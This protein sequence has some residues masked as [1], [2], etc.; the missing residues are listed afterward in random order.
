MSKQRYSTRQVEALLW[1]ARQKERVGTGISIDI[2]IFLAMCNALMSSRWAMLSC[3][4]TDTST[5]RLINV[6]AAH[7]VPPSEPE[8]VKQL[9]ASAVTALSKREAKVGPRERGDAFWPD[10]DQAGAA[11]TSGIW[12]SGLTLLAELPTK[13]G[14]NPQF[15]SMHRHAIESPFTTGDI[16]TIQLIRLACG[17]LWQ[18]PE[19]HLS[20]R[21]QQVLAGLERGLSE[22]QCAI[23]LKLSQHTVHQHVKTLYRRFQVC[24][25]S[26]LLVRRFARP[27]SVPTNLL[28]ENIRISSGGRYRSPISAMRRRA[29]R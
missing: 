8:I 7:V 21:L 5:P 2:K 3:F 23:E 15:L 14:E 18:R 12:K 26:E 16:A 13:A 19:L 28:H 22:K 1:I 4:Q 11:L 25:R 9:E 20:P 10:S 29:A 27:V 6:Q 24:S 17:S